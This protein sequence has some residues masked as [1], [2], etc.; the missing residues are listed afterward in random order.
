[1]MH[2]TKVDRTDVREETELPQ[3]LTMNADRTELVK[4][5]EHNQTNESI[6]P[7]QYSN[8]ARHVADN[9]VGDGAVIGQAMIG[10]FE[11]RPNVNTILHYCCRW[12]GRVEIFLHWFSLSVSKSVLLACSCHVKYAA[13]IPKN[14]SDQFVSDLLD[15][16]IFSSAIQRTMFCCQ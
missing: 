14:R 16:V 11:C 10:P 8:A 4:H 1:M 12:S 2:D 13:V 9:V 7:L 6:F 3:G 15:L 5:L